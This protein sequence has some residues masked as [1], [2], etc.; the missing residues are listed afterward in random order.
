MFPPDL[1]DH[2]AAW[3]RRRNPARLATVE[4]RVTPNVGFKAIDP[5]EALA[6][7]CHPRER[8]D[9][10]FRPRQVFL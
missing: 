10:E 6:A 1:I 3:S 7:L 4:N 5:A 2:A 9:P 8:G